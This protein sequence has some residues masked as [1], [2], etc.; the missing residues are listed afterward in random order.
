MPSDQIRTNSR[1]VV[2]S[3]VG[4]FLQIYGLLYDYRSNG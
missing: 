2:T 1:Y 4:T 3:D